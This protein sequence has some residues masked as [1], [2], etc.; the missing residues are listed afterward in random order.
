M[1]RRLLLLSVL[2]GLLAVPASAHAVELGEVDRAAKASCP[3]RCQALG[4]VSG[5]QLR[6]EGRRS[7]FKVDRAGRVTAFAVTLG[8]PSASAQRFF[9]STFGGPPQA[10]LSILRRGTKRKHRLVAQ[11]PAFDLTPHLG[12]THR[13]RLLE[14]LAVKKGYMV[15]LTVP[16]WAPAFAVDLS[17]QEGWRSSRDARRCA[18]VRQRAAQQR[19]GGLRTYG[20]FY[21]TARILYTATF[22]PSEEGDDEDEEDG[23]RDREDPAE[24]PDGGD[25]DAR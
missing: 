15:A 4:R 22:E 8:T 7:P 10:R 23:D 21:R 6:L 5:Y 24:N 13:F 12:T 9:T 19:V 25:R 11:S 14:P 1:M 18:D 2:A 16:T 3:E 20:C 17:S